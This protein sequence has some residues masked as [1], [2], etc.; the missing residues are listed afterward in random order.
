VQVIAERPERMNLIALFMRAALAERRET[1]ARLRPRGSLGLT[2]SGMSATLSFSRDRVLI[3]DGLVG[4]PN[5]VVE[6]SLEGFLALARGRMIAPLLSRQVRISGNPLAALPLAIVFRLT[7][8]SSKPG[9]GA[10]L[11]GLG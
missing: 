3:R 10:L 5:A 4:S 9:I 6:G 11:P 7:R 1:L 2:V 8:D